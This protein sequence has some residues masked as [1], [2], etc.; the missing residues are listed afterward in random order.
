MRHIHMHGVQIMM[1]A[2]TR[3]INLSATSCTKS[4]LKF[5]SAVPDPPPCP[6]TPPESNKTSSSVHSTMQRLVGYPVP[7][8]SLRNVLGNNNLTQNLLAH[9]Q[10]LLSSHH[11]VVKHMKFV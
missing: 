5:S 8:L 6:N 9:I 3:L 1:K 4:I 7:F 11:P 2:T 10:R